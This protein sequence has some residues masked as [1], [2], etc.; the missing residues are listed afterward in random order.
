MCVCRS[1]ERQPISCSRSTVAVAAP[2]RLTLAACRVLVR[3]SLQT[4]L[5]AVSYD[6][7]S[8]SR[9][10]AEDRSTKVGHEINKYI[11]A[12]QELSA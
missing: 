5:S 4:K 8:H 6:P 3:N 1:R 11:L 2:A 12:V 10:N 9:H 7:L